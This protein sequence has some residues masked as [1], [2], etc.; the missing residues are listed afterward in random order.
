[1]EASGTGESCLVVVELREYLVSFTFPVSILLAET[2]DD[3]VL[4]CDVAGGFAKIALLHCA[5]RLMSG[6]SL[7]EM[8]GLARLFVYPRYLWHTAGWKFTTRCVQGG[9]HMERE[10]NPSFA[11]GQRVQYEGQGIGTIT[12][13]GEASA[14]GERI[15]SY[16]IVFDSGN[17]V[18]VPMAK[19]TKYL[20]VVHDVVSLDAVVV[21]LKLPPAPQGRHW[22]RTE[23]KYRNLLRSGTTES[24]AEVVRDMHY[25]TTTGQQGILA[26]YRAAL[27]QIVAMLVTPTRTKAQVVE[28]LSK[29]TGLSLREQD[30]DPHA[31]VSTIGTKKSQK[32]VPVSQAKPVLAIAPP[33]VSSPQKPISTVRLP[34]VKKQVPVSQ[35]Q[36]TERVEYDLK[37]RVTALESLLHQQ[38]TA[39]ENWKQRASETG[40]ELA[41]AKV[42]IA[43]LERSVQAQTRA[44]NA[45]TVVHEEQ[46]SRLEAL[47]AFLALCLCVRPAA[48][49][50]SETVP[51]TDLAKIVALERT[52]KQ[53][54]RRN[55][56]L[57][58]ERLT[59]RQI[60]QRIERTRQE[61]FQFI[62][63]RTSRIDELEVRLKA[64]EKSKKAP[65]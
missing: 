20:Q 32:Y 11:V 58:Q 38:T 28:A 15:P 1:M 14:L 26:L 64:C 2:R 8:V 52:V 46:V 57:K 62:T 65:H 49:R 43:T 63:D 40:R 18:K 27:A 55:E 47:N 30:A 39:T 7:P 6:H 12:E 21:L 60:K 45:R 50:D 10:T 59:A 34:R 56:K 25:G 4:R 3:T 24:L 13:I 54:M 61:L 53:L 48:M 44:E 41:S 33:A 22:K 31:Y 19:A 9:T 23:E 29:A 17:R 36:S 16:E 51:S 35:V 5:P 37:Q 42:R